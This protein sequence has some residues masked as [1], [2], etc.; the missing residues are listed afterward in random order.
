MRTEAYD[1]SLTLSLGEYTTLLALLLRQSC[2]RVKQPVYWLCIHVLN[3]TQVDPE[4]R[5]AWHGAKIFKVVKSIVKFPFLLEM[6]DG[7]GA[8]LCSTMKLVHV[9]NDELLHA[10]ND[11]AFALSIIL[12]GSVNVFQR[13]NCWTSC[14]LIEGS[15]DALWEMINQ[16]VQDLMKELDRLVA[17]MPSAGMSTHS[18]FVIACTCCYDV[19]QRNSRPQ[20]LY[21]A[22]SLILTLF[23]SEF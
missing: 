20:D 18:I 15:K 7:C 22:D 8:D 16:T 13:S 9:G 19:N 10:Q 6:E 11:H 3:T 1:H 17:I 14:Q 21:H 23:L 4:V 12:N 5:T 2:T